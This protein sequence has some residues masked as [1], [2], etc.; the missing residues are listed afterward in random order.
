MFQ[1]QMVVF[2]QAELLQRGEMKCSEWRP[3]AIVLIDF[4]KEVIS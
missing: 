2:D 1:A 4:W 3:N